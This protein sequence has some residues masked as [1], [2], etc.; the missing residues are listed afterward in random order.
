MTLGFLLVCSD[1]KILPLQSLIKGK[2]Q[3]LPCVRYNKSKF[4]IWYW[5]HDPLN[6]IITKCYLRLPICFSED[7]S[8]ACFGT[9]SPSLS[10]WD[11]L[12]NGVPLMFLLN[13]SPS[14]AGVVFCFFS[15]VGVSLTFR[16]SVDKTVLQSLML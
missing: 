6:I 14:L 3:W 12:C 10:S 9:Q 5:M 16:L 15:F 7:P 1:Y 4:T 13:W 8:C 11:C 2:W